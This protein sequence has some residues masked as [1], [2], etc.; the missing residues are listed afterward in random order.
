MYMYLA[1]VY[2]KCMLNTLIKPFSLGQLFYV[3]KFQDT[4]IYAAIISQS[5]Q[6]AA[7][8]CN[9]EQ[10]RVTP[11]MEK[12]RKEKKPNSQDFCKIILTIRFYW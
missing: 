2:G 8:S 11:G 4:I 6:A 9:A 3:C 12:K 10:N 7:N 1:W 5:P